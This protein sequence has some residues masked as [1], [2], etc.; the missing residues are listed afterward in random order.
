[1]P[2]P[3]ALRRGD[4]RAGVSPRGEADHPPAA[5]GATPGHQDPVAPTNRGLVDTGMET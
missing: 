2:S 1:M 4:H 3:G 5:W